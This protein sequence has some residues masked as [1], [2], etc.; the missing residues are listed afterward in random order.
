VGI[1]DRATDSLDI[2][3]GE[4]GLPGHPPSGFHAGLLI[5]NDISYKDYHRIPPNKK[6]S[7]QYQLNVSPKDPNRNNK[8]FYITWDYPLS[9]YIDSA[10]FTD[11]INGNYA[12][13]TF[14]EKKSSPL[15]ETALSYFYINVWYN[16]SSVDVSEQ[17]DKDNDESISFSQLLDAIKIRTTSNIHVSLYSSLTSKLWSGNLNEGENEIK[18]QN[19]P[20][21]IYFLTLQKPNGIL[22]NHKIVI[23]R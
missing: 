14:D 8:P 10:K 19:L 2:N 18:T 11:R 23:I 3:L 15:I 12:S 1:D 17:Y 21:G 5:N 4:Q 7:V 22:T 13:F 16:V 9:Q 6:F 20:I